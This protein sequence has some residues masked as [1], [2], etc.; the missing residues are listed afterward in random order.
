[1]GGSCGPA[2]QPLVETLRARMRAAGLEGAIEFCPNLD[3]A[4]KLAFL[5]SLTVFSVPATYGEAFGLY[6]IEALAAGVPVVQPPCGAFPELI[7]ATGGGVLSASAEP[8]ALAEAIERL[9]LDPEGAR[10]LGE[11]GRRA[12]MEEYS[13]R[14]MAEK[15]VEILRLQVSRTVSETVQDIDQLP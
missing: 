15:T 8:R 3:R 7:A 12:V 13:A 2:D 1:V 10:K 14:R 5:E 11:T 9:L 4:Q 6:L